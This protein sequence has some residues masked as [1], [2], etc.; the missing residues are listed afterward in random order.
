MVGKDK[1][2]VPKTVGFRGS[3]PGYIEDHNINPVL[4]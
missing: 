2:T 1:E 3:L 4:A